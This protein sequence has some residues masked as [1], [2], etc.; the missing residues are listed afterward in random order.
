M[1]SSFDD[2][3]LAEPLRR[4]LTEAGHTTPT[5]IQA[6]AIPALL[7]G[8]DLQGVAQ[9]GTGKTAAFL[10]PLMTRLLA[11]PK[12]TPR[13]GCRALVLAPTRELAQQ[14]ADGFQLYGKKH[15]RLFQTVI[16][17]GVPQARQARAMARGVDLLVATPGRL[18]DLV[19]QRLVRLDAV[20]TLILDEADRM[21]DMGFAPA[22]ARIAKLIGRDRH[23]ILFS[24]TMPKAV[25]KL[26]AE[27]LRDPVRVEIPSES[28]AVER[29]E[30]R[31]HV[32]PQAEKRTFVTSLLGDPAMERVILFTRT[33]HGADR[34]QQHLE[35]A[36]VAA[37][38][39]H[40]NKAQGARQRALKRF[41]S[42]DARVLVATDIA[43]RGLDVQGITHVVN[44]DLPMEAETY[45]HR[46]G[47]TAR[48]GSAGVAISLCAPGEEK[49]LDQIRRYVARETEPVTFRRPR[50]TNVAKPASH[51]RRSPA[52][53]RRT[54]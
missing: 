41:K 46:I 37:E 48:A 26:A 23:T 3:G 42:G 51:R 15:T 34:V 49:Q 54:A 47:R 6:Q 18:E 40:G 7:Q 36:G 9:T 44:F 24:A 28:L 31:V 50:P 12:P 20:E 13:H 25:E 4:A 14:I 43:A 32:V 1:T 11:D 2:L 35:R 39:I 8:R 53:H 22:M 29:I 21:L 33:K 45:V 17:G 16:V 5:P 52:H 19:N 30:Q 27:L 10:L 38:A